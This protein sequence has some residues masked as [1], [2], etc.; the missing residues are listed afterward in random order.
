MTTIIFIA[1]IGAI[2][3]AV[4]GTFWY[5]GATPMGRLHMRYLGFDKLSQ[6]EKDALIAAAKPTMWKTYTAQMSLSL[7]TSLFIGF[8][9]WFTVQGGGPANAVY[10]YVPIIWIAF[11]VP[12]IGQNLLWGNTEP[13]LAWKKFFGDA[14]YNLIT[15]MLIAF[16]ATLLV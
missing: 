9:T 14:A 11:T 16:A 13:S 1:I 8:V 6:T 5:S 7:V 2:I 3:S 10:F 12:M 4:T 15:F